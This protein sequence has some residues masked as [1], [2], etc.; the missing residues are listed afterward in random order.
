MGPVAAYEDEV[1][2]FAVAVGFGDSEARLAALWTKASSESSPR[3]LVLSS[4]W[5]AVFGPDAGER[6]G[7]ELDFGMVG[8]LGLVILKIS[9]VFLEYQIRR[10]KPAIL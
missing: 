3:R 8:R 6:L 9:D 5:R 1:E 10:G 2:T 4:R 7:G